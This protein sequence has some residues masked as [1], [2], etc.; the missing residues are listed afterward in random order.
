MRQFY[1]VD[2]IGST[3]F[4]DY[5]SSTLISDLDG[6]GVERSNT[7]LNFDGTYKLAKREN[8]KGTISGTLTFLKGYEGYTAFLAFLKKT[9]GSL[10]LFYKADNLKYIYV[11]VSSVS[12]SELYYGVLQCSI[13]FDK[14]SMWLSKI[15]S[16][17]TV[18]ETTDNKVFPFT[19]PFT[20]S[21]S[22][23][24]E[25]CVSNVGCIRA[26]VRLEII[27]KTKYPTIEI[28]K[29]EEVVSTMRL[30]VSTNNA[31]DT[32]VVDSI[33]TEQEMTMTVN[34]VK[35]DIYQDQDFSCENFLYLGIGTY[36]IRFRP[37]LSEP[38]SC[39]VSFI[40][41]FEGN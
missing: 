10:R 31:D 30:L 25:I 11:E 17:I 15:S 1:L 36:K 16:V 22:Y 5:R 35:T 4:F 6:L 40:E 20:Y 28:I 7:Y 13:S 37:G 39:K 2:E 8:P 23:D 3:F 32:I 18:N 41:M 14:L 9:T 29:D 24:G 27:G 26:P 21:S 12:K 19:Y 33:P 38:S 34:G